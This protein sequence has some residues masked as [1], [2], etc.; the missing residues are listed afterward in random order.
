[1]SKRSVASAVLTI[2]AIVIV[3]AIPVAI[4]IA[5]VTPAVA[6]SVGLSVALLCVIV[7]GLLR[8]RLGY[9]LGWVVQ[10]LAIAMGFVVPTMFFLGAVFALLWF[11][12]LRLGRAI[13]EQQRARETP[14]P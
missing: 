5:D 4:V 6:V 13:E 11:L 1:M 8:R 3:L 12:T 10:V 2:E 14:P 9:Q 7:A